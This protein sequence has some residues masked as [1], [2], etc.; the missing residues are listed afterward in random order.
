MC[1]EE[2]PLG[3]VFV[4]TGTAHFCTG[5]KPFVQFG[6]VYHHDTTQL[7]VVG[8]ENRNAFL[9]RQHSNRGVN[10]KGCAVAFCKLPLSETHLFCFLIYPS[11]SD[12][13]R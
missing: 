7:T 5:A 6:V 4:C 11:H 9:H 2:M 10:G 13:L 12:H 8:L 3:N 1:L